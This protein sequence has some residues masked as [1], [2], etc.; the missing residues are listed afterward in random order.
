MT[1]TACPTFCLPLPYLFL[2]LAQILFLF[3]MTGWLINVF[4][5]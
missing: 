2:N 5:I 3:T 1:G 4:T